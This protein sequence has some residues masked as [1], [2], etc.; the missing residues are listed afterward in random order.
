MNAVIT[1]LKNAHVKLGQV[2]A[3]LELIDKSEPKDKGR[4]G[5]EA[6]VSMYDFMESIFDV[7]MEV[8]KSIRNLV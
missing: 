8:Y 2:I 1:K 7:E 3:L 6:Y 5:T 4:I